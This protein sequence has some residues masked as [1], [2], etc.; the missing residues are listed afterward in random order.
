MDVRNYKYLYGKKTP[1]PPVAFK[2]NLIFAMIKSL[3]PVNVSL[4]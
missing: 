2:K 4:T 1:Y 3:L